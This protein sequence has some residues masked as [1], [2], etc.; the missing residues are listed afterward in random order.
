M[1]AKLK[2][3][4]LWVFCLGFPLAVWECYR[5]IPGAQA[6]QPNATYADLVMVLFAGLTVA[7]ALFAVIAGLLAIWG[8]SNIKQEAATAAN[9][10]VESSI[11]TAVDRHLND[12]ALG[13]TIRKELRPIVRDVIRE[14]MP[15]DHLAS[16]LY[17]T[18][19]PQAP[20]ISGETESAR[21]AEELPSEDDETR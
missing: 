21:I 9:A 14:E 10:A 18:A 6:N 1:M 11:K 2:M 19:F 17:A 3:A 7:L 12:E 5:L 4:A 16:P 8:Y 13:A 15:R 20:E